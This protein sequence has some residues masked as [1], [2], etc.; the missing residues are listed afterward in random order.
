MQLTLHVTNQCNLRCKYCFV[1][2][3][4]ERM[5]LEVA[6]AAVELCRRSGRR[7]GVLFYGGEPLLEQEMIKE[8]VEGIAVAN[9]AEDTSSDASGTKKHEFYFK[10]TSN[11]TLLDEDFLRFAQVHDIAYNLSYDGPV[12]DV[13]RV[14]PGG[15]GSAATVEAKIPLLLQYQPYAVLMSVVE[16]ETAGRAAEMVEDFFAR[17]F[18]YITLN[19]NYGAEWVQRDFDALARSYEKMAR[20]YVKWTNAE[21]KFYLS[22][23]DAKIQAHLKGAA[24]H[25]DRRAMTLNQPSVAP[26]G[27]IYYGSRG[28]SDAAYEIGDVFAGIDTERHAAV[29][30]TMTTPPSECDGCA[31]QHRCNYGGYAGPLPT[32]C[33]HEQLITPI[34]D[35][36]AEKLYRKRSALFL[37]KH[38]NDLYPL[39]SLI[40]DR[41]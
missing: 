21:E 34:V 41:I 23:F 36:M 10:M 35:R 39:M 13:C 28:L 5:S 1:T 26:D 40:D 3:G 16:P 2:H 32:Q 14:F 33:A 27:R 9:A 8:L 29:H 20:L 15:K 31:I 25:T 7:S 37:H 22:P 30:K 4:N 17:G 18:R 24:Y 38:Y 12:H 6:R 19:L 11:G